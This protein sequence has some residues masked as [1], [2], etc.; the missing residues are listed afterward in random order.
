[1]LL[2][3]RDLSNK[4]L[5]TFQQCLIFHSTDPG[6]LN[7]VVAHDEQFEYR[8]ADFNLWIDGIGALAPS[9]ASLDSR[10]SQRQIDLSLIKGNLIM[11]LQSL[12][13]C[14][15]LV[16]TNQSLQDT[17]LDIDSALESLVSISLAVRRTGRKSRL[18][19]ADRLFNQEEHKELRKHLEAIILLRPGEGPCDGDNE[20]KQ[21]M[22]SLTAIQNHLVMAN[23]KRRNRYIQAHLHSLGLKKR[24]A[25]IEQWPIHETAERVTTATASSKGNL[26]L[27]AVPPATVFPP[28]PSQPL[29]AAPMSVTSASIPESKLEYKEPVAKKSDSTPATVSGEDMP[30]IIS[31]S[32]QAKM[33]I[34]NCPLCEVQ[35][36]VDSPQLIDHVLEHIHDFSL[37]SLPW[38]ASSMVDMGGEVGSFNSEFEASILVTQWL[39][40]YE[41]VTKDIDPNLKLSNCDY[42][43]LAI[44]AEQIQSR[45]LDK[46][47]LD[48][49]FADEHGDESAEAETDISQL[50][51]D[52]L[53]SLKGAN[54]ASEADEGHDKEHGSEAV[55][56]RTTKRQSSTGLRKLTSRIFSRNK[57]KG[58]ESGP[59][60]V[61]GLG[62]LL[63]LSP[64]AY[65][66]LANLYQRRIESTTIRRKNPFPEFIKNVQGENISATNHTVQDLH[67]FLQV[68]VDSHLCAL[69][70]I[71]PKDLTKTISNYFINTSSNSCASL[72]SIRQALRAGYRSLDIE[73][74][75]GDDAMKDV[76]QPDPGVLYAP[77]SSSIRDGMKRLTLPF[78]KFKDAPVFEVPKITLSIADEPVSRT[79]PVVK[80]GWHFSEA[81]SFRDVCVLIRNT[82]FLNNAMPI[83]VN[84]TVHAG[85]DQ[86]QTMVDIM[87]HEWLGLLID[88]PIDDCDPRLELPQLEDLQNRILVKASRPANIQMDRDL[89]GTLLYDDLQN[90]PLIQQLDSLNVYLRSEIFEGFE[91]SQSKT[92]IHVF[93]WQ[94]EELQRLI[95]SSAGNLL[96]HN[97][98]YLCR[99]NPNSIQ[100]KSSNLDPSHFWK[101]GVHMV[102][103]NHLIVDEGL[104]VNLGIFD[105]EEGWV[106]KPFGYQST[107]DYISNHIGTTAIRIA[108]FSI[109]VFKDQRF[110][111]KMKDGRVER[112]QDLSRLVEA[113]IHSSGERYPLARQNPGVR[114]GDSEAF[115]YGMAINVVTDIIPELT[116]ITMTFVDYSHGEGLIAWTS[117]RLDRLNQGYRLIPLFNSSGESFGTQKLLVKIK[118]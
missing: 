116:V 103:I 98:H 71:P 23:L 46:P 67:S 58:L 14:L 20:F 65:E 84:F 87:K 5:E 61:E 22:N 31:S 24:S 38:P 12:E 86:Q 68:M 113:T 78:A 29:A 76:H 9:K 62:H 18:Y 83:I 3:A 7:Q 74:W 95:H 85:A 106:S 101:Y 102:A 105:D 48:I 72:D 91:S 110:Y 53:D 37:R 26:G 30:A 80:G 59:K 107:N 6:L 89:S 2:S 28:E 1:M 92:P 33:G 56:N 70:P 49:Y 111:A 117:L 44:I 54:Q 96:K 25:G 40:G 39:E 112:T 82:A 93:T 16:K 64:Q 69:K 42:G 63:G 47:G 66:V 94:E 114:D 55:T 10:L 4:C 35:G 99:V 41:H 77:S 100:T 57:N 43:R 45:E 75:D 97:K 32:T 115:G 90:S 108:K 17:L 109:L 34:R 60:V 73:V 27:T 36:E 104:M 19:K 21:K 88:K 51:Q 8:L 15:N 50:T 81:F 52:T 79:S 118:F 13:D 11:L